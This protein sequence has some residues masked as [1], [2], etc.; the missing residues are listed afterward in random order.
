MDPL[1]LFGLAV[2]SFFSGA[3]NAV[4]G[5][6]T[7]IA[8]PALIAFGF[9]PKVANVTSKVAI[10]P[11]T[12]G[13]ALA[14][15]GELKQRRRRIIL[16]TI[17]AII[18]A[19]AGSV[20][21]L[22]SSE[23]LFNVVV[24]HL[25]ILSSVLLAVDRPL[26]K[27]AARAGMTATN[28]DHIPPAL[29]IAIFFVS[30]YGA[31]FGAGLGILVLSAMS[32]F[33]ADDIQHANAVKG[34]L[35]L[36]VNFVALVVFS[37]FGPVQWLAAVLMAAFA[38]TGGYAGVAVARRVPAAQLRWGMVVWGLLLGLKLLFFP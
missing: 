23:Q 3:V 8:F 30:I 24:P 9:D 34:I 28:A 6:G 37:L 38:L 4:A 1:V 21:L 25:V 26:S 32:I 16:L 7:L 15:R 35:Q 33:A 10:W 11:G 20:L 22:M 18:G 31:Y 14:Y 36:L 13:G 17:P 2:A 19:L 29:H 12:V 5:G 27:I